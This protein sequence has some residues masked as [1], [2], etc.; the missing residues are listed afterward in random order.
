MIGAAIVPAMTN[1]AH[2]TLIP[3]A[4]A[5]PDAAALLLLSRL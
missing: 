4:F 3:G 1:A 5:R 2:I